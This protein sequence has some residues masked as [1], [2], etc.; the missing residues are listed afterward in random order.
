MWAFGVVAVVV[1]AVA[2]A[3]FVH[4][5]VFDLVAFV[6][7]VASALVVYFAPAFVP[8]VVVWVGKSRSLW[9]FVVH[10]VAVEVVASFELEIV[11]FAAVEVAF[12]VPEAGLELV[13]E[14]SLEFALETAFAG[15][16]LTSQAALVA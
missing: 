14:L 1:A 16:P 4:L 7:L 5:V 2:A 11:E 15:A 8:V 3:V 6:V 10:V 13:P 12:V 9:S